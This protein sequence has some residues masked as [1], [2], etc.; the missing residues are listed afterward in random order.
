M[1]PSTRFIARFFGHTSDRT[2]DLP[3]NVV[4]P[5][6][7]VP[8]IQKSYIVLKLG[9]KFIAPC[10]EPKRGYYGPATVI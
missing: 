8:S 6:T 10:I 7:S 2:H 9:Q 5:L 3:I 4:K 1:L